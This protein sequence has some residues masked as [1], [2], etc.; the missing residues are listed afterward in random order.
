MSLAG[1]KILLVWPEDREPECDCALDKH[2][3]EEAPRGDAVPEHQSR[4]AGC[5]HEPAFE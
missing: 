1:I 5:G 4:G 3:K 2:E